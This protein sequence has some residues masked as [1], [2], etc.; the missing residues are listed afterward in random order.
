MASR[1][2][3][4]EKK[5]QAKQAEEVFK[6]AMKE[7][8]YRCT[9]ERLTVLR[10]IYLSDSHLDADEIFVKLKKKNVSIS[11]ATVYHTLDLLFKFHL[12]NKIDLGHKHTHYEK[13]YGVSNHLHIICEQCDRVVEVHSEELN[14]ILERL[15]DENGF[16]LGS[17][18]LQVFARCRDE[19]H[20]G[21]CEL[22]TQPAH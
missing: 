2:K 3:T 8:G 14:S 20:T 15:C 11:R 21:N 19:G 22:K 9:R 12:V 5:E 1:T 6:A 4:R 16:T 18:S 13:S 10:E 7:E 17:Y